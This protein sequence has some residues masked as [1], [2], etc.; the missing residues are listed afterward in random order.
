[1]KKI[2][3]ILFTVILLFT[4]CYNDIIQKIDLVQIESFQSPDTIFLNEI[5][6]LQ[7]NAF[8]VNSCWS[9]LF[10][11]LQ[12]EDDF[13]YSVKAF[14]TYNCREGGCACADVLVGMDTIINFQPNKKGKYIFQISKNFHNEEITTDTLVV[15]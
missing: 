5:A 10:V 12:K 1:M 6:P 15:L 4:G 2:F 8:A 11:E 3:L 9:D 7:V 13:D 14:G